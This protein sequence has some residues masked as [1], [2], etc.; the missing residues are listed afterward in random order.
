MPPDN[1]MSDVIYNLRQMSG[2]DHVG[3]TAIRAADEIERL[4]G[5]LQDV[6]DDMTF[7]VAPSKWTMDKIREAMQ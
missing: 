1:Q 4:R 6:I 3:Q 2:T 5:L 7:S